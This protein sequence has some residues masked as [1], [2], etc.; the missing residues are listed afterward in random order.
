MLATIIACSGDAFE[1]RPV[2]FEA[3]TSATVR[4]S[5][6]SLPIASEKAATINSNVSKTEIVMSS[7]LAVR[8]FGARPRTLATF[9]IAVLVVISNSLQD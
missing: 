7:R 9:D 4:S 8:R 2:N 3:M 6:R 5:I 1:I